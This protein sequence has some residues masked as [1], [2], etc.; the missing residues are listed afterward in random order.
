MQRGY[1]K[2]GDTIIV[3]EGIYREHVNPKNGGSGD[4]E[5]ITYEAAPGEKVAIS[6]A[7]GRYC[8]PLVVHIG[9][10]PPYLSDIEFLK[11]ATF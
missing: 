1:D 9:G 6:G 11:T 3:H 5:R 2:A 8:L 4:N 10:T 7:E